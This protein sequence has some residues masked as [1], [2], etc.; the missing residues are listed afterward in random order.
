MTA[1]RS[2]VIVA[3]LTDRQTDGKCWSLKL[4]DGRKILDGGI[5]DILTKIMIHRQTDRHTY[6]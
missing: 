3:I 1:I 2:C 5:A 6:E 4:T